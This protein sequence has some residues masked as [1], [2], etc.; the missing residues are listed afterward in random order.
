MSFVSVGYPPD[1]EKNALPCVSSGGVGICL[2][3]FAGRSD[4]YAGMWLMVASVS[5]CGDP[6]ALVP[7]TV[8]LG[9]RI[10]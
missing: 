6:G 3:A 7:R 2:H 4:G 8:P 9:L 1:T 5:V 10:R